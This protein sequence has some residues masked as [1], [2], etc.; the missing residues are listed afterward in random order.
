MTSVF[1]IAFEALKAFQNID[2]C[3]KGSLIAIQIKRKKI[4]SF[5]LVRCV[6]VLEQ[7]MNK[8]KTK[9]EIEQK[10]AECCYMDINL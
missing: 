4:Y 3:N 5:D 8:K 7:G 6:D 2:I 10:K 9:F 1:I